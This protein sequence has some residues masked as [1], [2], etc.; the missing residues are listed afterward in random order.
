MKKGRKK[1]GRWIKM[2]QNCL[3]LTQTNA[4][5]P[6]VTVSACICVRYSEIPLWAEVKSQWLPVQ[7]HGKPRKATKCVPLV[8]LVV[9]VSTRLLQ[10]WCGYEHFDRRWI[11]NAFDWWT[12]SSSRPPLEMSSVGRQG[13]MWRA[14]PILTGSRM[15]GWVERWKEAKGGNRKVDEPMIKGE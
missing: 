8:V 3:W 9:V 15:D 12:G 1:T 7:R 10:I 2:V 13:R 4:G 5:Q 14:S 11:S 6:T